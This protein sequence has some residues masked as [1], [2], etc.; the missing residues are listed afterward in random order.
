MTFGQMAQAFVG[1]PTDTAD[2]SIR[3]N[4]CPDIDDPPPSPP[5]F[6]HRT[7]TVDAAQRRTGRHGDILLS[8]ATRS[9]DTPDRPFDFHSIPPVPTIIATPLH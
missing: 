3:S 4:Y 6:H 1:Q 8:A 5:S 7:V 2:A 9:T